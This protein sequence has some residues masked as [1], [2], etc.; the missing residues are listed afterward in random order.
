MRRAFDLARLGFGFVTPNPVVGAVLVHEGR[1][2]G[3]GWHRRVGTAHAEVNA[4]ASVAPQ[5]RPLIAA[6]TLYVSLEPCCVFGR[7]PPCTD[8][9]LRERIPRVVISQLDHSPA[10]LRQGVA[11]L[12][13]AGVTVIT[14]LLPD[15][16][17]HISLARQVYVA[18]HRPLILLKYARSAD[19][20]LAPAHG[21]DYWITHPISRRLVHRWRTQTGAV[22]I[23][24]GTARTDD[25]A[26]TARYFP[27]PQPLRVVVDPAGRLTETAQLLSSPTP[28]LLFSTDP[29]TATWPLRHPHLE[30]ITCPPTAEAWMPQVLTALHER[31]INHLTVEGGAH[32]LNR[33][34]ESGYWDEALVFTGQDVYFR[35]G[36]T[37]PLPDGRPQR[38]VQLLTDRID[39]YR[40]PRTL[41]LF[42]GS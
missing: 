30:V 41:A 37:A 5:D 9:I 23:G 29:S 39:L 31:G 26:L 6:A 3:E 28:L 16:G 19:G 15:E 17:L 4:V 24:G 35:G 42:A 32:T 7:T 2:I 36:L 18:Q 22:L 25:P 13:E 27:G 33:F 21:G 14:D 10:V 20:F 1:I 12:R 11:R 38:S 8:L 34:L 40:N